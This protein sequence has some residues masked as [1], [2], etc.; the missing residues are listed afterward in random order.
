MAALTLSIGNIFP[1]EEGAVPEP[2]AEPP[3]VLAKIRSVHHRAARLIAS[4]MRLAD[5]AS[6]TGLNYARLSMLKN[7]PLFSELL[8]HYSTLEDETFQNVREKVADLG[9]T[10]AEVLHERLIEN[11]ETMSNKDLVNLLQ[12]SLDRGGYAPVQKSVSLSGHIDA[13]ALSAM[14]AAL[15]SAPERII[16]GEAHEISEEDSGPE[17]SE[18]VAATSIQTEALEGLP[19]EGDSI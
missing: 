6:A 19:G 13:E 8:A 1:L 16:E 2:G 10:T 3:T 15:G 14:K 12:V 18:P 5:V 17:I 11:P 9:V 7:D 4:G